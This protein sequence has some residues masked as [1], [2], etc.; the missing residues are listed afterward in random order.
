MSELKIFRLSQDVNG[1]YDTYNDC[2][3]IAENKEEA[4]KMH[5]DGRYDY[6]EGG[7][8]PYNTDETR[9]EKADRDYGTWAKKEFVNVEE[10]GEAK[11]DAEKGVVCA[12][13]NAG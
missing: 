7:K 10:I 6:E 5:P 2:V 12:S 13:F 11:E 1:G 9:F 3:V 8:N 4:K